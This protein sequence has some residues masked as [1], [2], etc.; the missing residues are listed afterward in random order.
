MEHRFVR[1]THG[2]EADL[3]QQLEAMAAEGWDLEQAFPAAGDV[4]LLFSRAKQAPAPE[5]AAS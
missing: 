4:V 5:A 1:V 3:N 2:V